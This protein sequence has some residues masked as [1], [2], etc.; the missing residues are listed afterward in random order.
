MRY[1]GMLLL[2]CCIIP[3]WAQVEAPKDY[4]PTDVWV[5]VNQNSVASVALGEFYCQARSVPLDHLIKLDLPETE[6]MSR[7]EYE[8]KLLEPLREKLK[9]LEQKDFILL[10]TYGVP[11]RV[12]AAQPGPE[13]QERLVVIRREQE[14]VKGQLAELEDI[15]KNLEA[16][17]EGS[18]ARLYRPDVE[19]LTNLKNILDNQESGFEQRESYADVDSELAMIWFRNYPLT[20]WQFNIRYFVV[21]ESARARMPRIVLTCRI[22]GPNP[23][24]AKRIVEDAI[25]AEEAGGPDGFAYVDA[26]GMAWDKNTD[27]E[28]G[29]YG[30]F[31]ESLREFAQLLKEKGF[32]T[33]LNNTED[34][35]PP[36]SCPRTA[37]YCGWYALQAYRP[38]CELVTGSIAYHVAS[39]EA[40]SPRKKD[41][42][43][44]VPNLLQ[45]GAC[46]TLGP[47]AEPYL[48]SFP[49]PSIFF[50]FLLSGHTVVESYWLS[51]P[52]ASWQQM[53]IG[54]PLYRPW[55]K[56]PRM[57][58]E[59]VV[60]SPAGSVFPRR[61][62]R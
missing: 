11:I 7:K 48:M 47:V 21:Q 25:K 26:R 3:G 52:L 58:S 53:I 6:E 50:G 59:E 15:M 4:Q 39:F 49:K 43:R 16:A 36:G 60:P 30:G 13:A 18:K 9:A 46:V 17:G 27:L 14:R 2:C 1:F 8:E 20:R 42:P 38:C 35:F 32:R 33:T 40:V 12:G 24:V 54:D 51:C 5:V 34:L 55:G 10:T 29:S 45:D 41:H 44:W 56:K 31:D 22:D 61:S 23:A 62:P 57:K 28:G 19:R 37:I